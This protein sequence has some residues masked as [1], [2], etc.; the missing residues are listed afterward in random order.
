MSIYIK[1]NWVYRDTY[2]SY[3]LLTRECYHYTSEQAK[4]I[5]ELM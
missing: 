4:V 1:D 5:I 2:N 3:E